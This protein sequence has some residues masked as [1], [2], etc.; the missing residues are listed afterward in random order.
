MQ[1][2]SSSP[3]IAF[4]WLR[5]IIF[6]VC[7]ML[8]LGGVTLSFAYFLQKAGFPFDY[9]NMDSNHLLIQSFITIISALIPTWA[10]R[11]WVDRKSFASLGFQWKNFQHHGYTGLFVSLFIL[12]AGTLLLMG[13]SNISYVGIDFTPVELV[14]LLVAMALVAVGEEL[15]VRGYLL[16]NFMESFPKW[17]SLL[18]TALLFSAL[19][20]F[21]ASANWMSI[22]GIFTGGL[23]L[24]INYIFTK[25]LWYGILF[26]F[27]WNFFQGPIL[28][29]Q[30]S[31]IEIESLLVHTTKGSPIWT[32]GAFGFEASVIACVLN[33]IVLAGLTVY[34]SKN[35]LQ[36]Q[37]VRNS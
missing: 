29:Y 35:N 3:L 9:K 14:K 37:L 17:V 20:I 4:G 25:N 36:P 15:V 22:V 10:F 33:L 30:V 13:F 2:V 7:W 8:V 6:F 28:G 34:Y 31:G 24:G 32:G 26:H 23:L 21:N 11:K 19:H 18:I 16:N 5:A 1:K 12:S 27:A